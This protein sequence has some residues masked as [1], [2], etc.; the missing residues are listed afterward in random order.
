MDVQR[1]HSRRGVSE[2]RMCNWHHKSQEQKVD[3]RLARGEWMMSFETLPS[4]QVV[5]VYGDI[6]TTCDMLMDRSWRLWMKCSLFG[7]N[8]TRKLLE[9]LFGWVTSCELIVGDCSCHGVLEL[10]IHMC[11]CHHKTQEQKV[12][13]GRDKHHKELIGSVFHLDEWLVVNWLIVGPMTCE[14]EISHHLH[15]VEGPMWIGHMTWEAIAF[16]FI[17]LSNFQGH[18]PWIGVCASQNHTHDMKPSLLNLNYTIGKIFC[19]SW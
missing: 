6:L 17:P 2:L 4:I 13:W 12:D 16:T 14:R 15:E 9:V 10:H 8:I 18:I 5:Y 3:C 11:N 7:Q 19:I 1:I